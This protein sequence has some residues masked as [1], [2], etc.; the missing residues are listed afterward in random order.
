MG[1]LVPVAYRTGIDVTTDVLLHRRPPETLLQN[2]VGQ[3]DSRVE[4]APTQELKSEGDA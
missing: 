4:G 2:I 1:G 3:L